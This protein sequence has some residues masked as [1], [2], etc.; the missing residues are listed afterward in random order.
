MKSF[1]IIIL[2]LLI[3]SCTSVRVNYDYEM[4]TNFSQYKTYNYYADMETGLNELD[5]KR[6]F[7]ILDSQLQQKGLQLS[8]SPD[9]Y[10]NIKSRERETVQ[11][12]T[13]GVGVGGA[14]RNVG[15]GIS[16]GIPIGQSSINRQIIFDFVDESNT[17]L[18]WQAATESVFNPNSTPKKK[19]EQFKLIVNKILS[20]YPPKNKK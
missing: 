6:L 4:T 12:N 11:R 14:G 5:A 2:S 15:G 9:F 13:V 7:D 16:V 10:I 8:D 19:E 1:R 17:G 3:V 18:F 20:V